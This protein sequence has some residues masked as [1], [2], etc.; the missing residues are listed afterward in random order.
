MK[1]ILGYKSYESILKAY[2]TMVLLNHGLRVIFCAPSIIL[3]FE[4]NLNSMKECNTISYSYIVFIIIYCPCLYQLQFVSYLIT[5]AFQHKTF[6]TIEQEDLH[7]CLIQKKS[8]YRFDLWYRSHNLFAPA[9]AEWG[10]FVLDMQCMHQ[11]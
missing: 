3:H 2:H 10:V 6:L 9:D 4:H 11:V 8:F 7:G 5:K 1:L